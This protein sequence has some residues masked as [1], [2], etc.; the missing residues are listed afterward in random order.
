MNLDTLENKIGFQLGFLKHSDN[1][2]ALRRWGFRRTKLQPT[3]KA[4]SE[5]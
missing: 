3:T 2:F 5:N 1:V 4:K